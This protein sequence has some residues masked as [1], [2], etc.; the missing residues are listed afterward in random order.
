[1]TEKEK[2]MAYDEAVKRAKELYSKNSIDN[3]SSV[4][5]IFPELKKSESERITEEIIEY[6][7]NDLNNINQLTPRT[8]QFE[9]WLEYLKSH[10]NKFIN[11]AITWIEYN[12]INGGCQFDGWEDNFKEYIKETI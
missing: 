3:Y 2:A 1:M 5:Y 4:E 8:N 6:L 7:Y 12:N 9:S 10:R 11:A